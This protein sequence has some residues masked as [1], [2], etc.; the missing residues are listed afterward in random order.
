MNINI[1]VNEVAGGWAPTDKR[2]GGTEE[3]VVEWA[4]QFNK[5]GHHVLV[6]HNGHTDQA[7]VYD[8]IGYYPRYMYDGG[9]DVCINVKSSDI[10][11]LEP[12]IYYTNEINAGK[13]DL[14][15]YDTVVWPSRWARFNIEV[16]NKNINVIPHGYDK[17]KIIPSKRKRRLRCLYASSPDRGLET[18]QKIWPY[19]IE[20]FPNAE[21][22]VTY[23]GKLD[24]PNVIS[25]DFTEEE[26]NKL[27]R[28]SDIWLYPM[29]E[30]AIELFCITGKKAQ[31]AGCIPVVIPR[32]ALQETVK[33]GI[34]VENE[35]DFLDELLKLMSMSSDHRNKIREKVI[36]GADAITWEKS[37]MMLLDL[38]NKIR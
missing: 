10:P 26:V 2:L 18:L 5:M 36:S 17:N 22:Y 13:L 37:A 11:R 9:G 35:Y 38:A 15:Q 1:V 4:K 12:T 21:L 33:N 24:L 19:V 6:F 16:N 23:N 27:Y 8:N 7:E 30:D 31:I 25:G 29:S 28:S 32:M 20:K 34:L 3:S 14:S